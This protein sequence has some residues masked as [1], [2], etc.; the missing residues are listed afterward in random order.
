MCFFG[1]SGCLIQ[2]LKAWVAMEAYAHDLGG[3]GILLSFQMLTTIIDDKFL[4]NLGGP[5]ATSYFKSW[6]Q[7]HTVHRM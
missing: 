2:D 1:F 3:R 7:A 5:T 4:Q 6:P